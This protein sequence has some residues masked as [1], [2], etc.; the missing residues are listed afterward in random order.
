[1]AGA[2]VIQTTC[3]TLKDAERIAEALLEAGLA[4]CV[5]IAEI[6]SRYVWKGAVQRAPE[7]LLLIKTREE[8]FEAVRAKLSE[9]HPYETPEI[10]AVPASAVDADY[11]A[12]LHD[13]TQRK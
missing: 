11:L 3:A 1:V 7:Q 9:V 6:R 13:A 4:A 10:L 12:W 5:Q 2:V 8:L